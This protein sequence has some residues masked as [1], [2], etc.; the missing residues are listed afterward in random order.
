[1]KLAVIDWGIGGLG[2]YSTWKKHRPEDAIIYLSD[3][4]FT[5]YGKLD[6]IVLRQRLIQMFNY[7]KNTQGVT[8]VMVACNAASSVIYDIPAIRGLKINGLIEGTCAY[9]R[10]YLTNKKFTFIGGTRTIESEIYVKKL[11]DLNISQRTAQPLSALVER[12]IIYGHEAEYAIR[13]IFE[14]IGDDD[15]VLACTHYSAMT[16]LIGESFPTVNCHDPIPFIVKQILEKWG[17]FYS[18]EDSFLTTGNTI[19]S[20]HS[21]KL[22]FGIVAKF[23]HTNIG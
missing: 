19:E 11:A 10:E 17:K 12:G 9:V 21:A 5:P 16:K 23:E 13:E 6:A 14:G 2:F 4:G 7:L 1:M 3:S 15:V 20:D 22:A 8:H 18:G